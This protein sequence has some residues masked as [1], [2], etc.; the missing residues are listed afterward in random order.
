MPPQPP[1]RPPWHRFST[2]GLAALWAL[3]LLA[4]LLYGHL[5]GRQGDPLNVKGVPELRRGIVSLELPW[6]VEVARRQHVALVDRGLLPV[7]R[8][9]LRLDAGYLLLYPLAFNLSAA[10]AARLGRGWP[11][12]AARRLAG[13]VLLAGVLDAGENAVLL[14]LLNGHL[15]APWPLLCSALATAKFALL[16]LTGGVVLAAL[17]QRLADHWRQRSGP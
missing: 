3:V 1:P 10:L 15:S 17:A 6:T 2:R 12:R 11:A 14:H 9:Q 7:A 16:V 4:T 13:P 5:L 8:Q